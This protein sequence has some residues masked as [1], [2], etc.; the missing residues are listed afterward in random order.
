MKHTAGMTI[1]ARLGR[2]LGG[3][4]RGWLRAE[5]RVHRWLM[6][7]GLPAGGA[8]V[9]IWGGKLATLG[10]LLYIAVWAALLPVA[11]VVAARMAEQAPQGDDDFLGRKAEELDH[12]ESLAYDPINYSDD[13]DPRFEDD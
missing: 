1:A 10:V 13:P 5:R 12:R 3:V 11:L 8:A 4:W 9:L 2:W 6:A 7:Q